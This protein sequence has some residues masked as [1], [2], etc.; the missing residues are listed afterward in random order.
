MLTRLT[1]LFS[2]VV[3]AFPARAQWQPNGTALNGG[4]VPQIVSDGSGGAL[5]TWE[6]WDPW[7]G[8][9]DFGMA[10]RLDPGGNTMWLPGGGKL[11]CGSSD[12][13]MPQVVSDGAGGA[14]FVFLD[15]RSGY[16]D[17]YAQRINPAGSEQWAPCGVPVRVLPIDLPYEDVAVV[18]DGAGGVI[19]AWSDPRGATPDIYAQHLDAAGTP[20]W[21]T[22]GGALCMAAGVQRNPVAVADGSGGVWVA[23]NDSRSGNEDI[24]ARHIHAEGVPEGVPDGLA[25]CAA[26]GNQFYPAIDSDEAGGGRGRR[27]AGPTQRQRDR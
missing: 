21:T 16:R 24:Y 4:G 20:L 9:W 1:F 18:S 25:V 8:Q 10:Q 15:N 19:I 2:I 12:Q 26:V 27:V 11:L 13:H 6:Y 17:I 3:I 7:A 23:W 14:I 22:N 5:V